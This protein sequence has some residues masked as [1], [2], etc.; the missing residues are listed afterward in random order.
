MKVRNA[1]IALITV[2]SF[3]ILACEK[4]QTAPSPEL[5]RSTVQPLIEGSRFPLGQSGQYSPARLSVA[6]LDMVGSSVEGQLAH[7]RVSVTVVFSS[8]G[9]EVSCWG[10]TVRSLGTGV[11]SWFALEGLAEG[12]CAEGRR[13]SRTL[14]LIYRRYDTGWQLESTNT[15]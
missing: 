14:D 9:V 12:S 10:P 4:T 13:I 11:A 7:V 5:V 1:L 8:N 15:A 6:G 2:W 3:S